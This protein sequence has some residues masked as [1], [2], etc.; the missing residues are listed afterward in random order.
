MPVV[1]LSLLWLLSGCD[2]FCC[3]E[4]EICC[5]CCQSYHCCRVVIVS[6]FDIWNLLFGFCYLRFVFRVVIVVGLWLFFVTS[7]RLSASIW[8]LLW[9]LWLLSGCDCFLLFGF[10]CLDF[11]IWILLF[12][13]DLHN[14]I[15]TNAADTVA[16]VSWKLSVIFLPVCFVFNDC[17][18]LKFGNIPGFFVKLYPY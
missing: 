11:V 3:L 10:C 6:K 14:I 16:G 8:N 12:V 4:F 7:T 2:C 17:I 13:V 9:L 15:T 18:Q 5:L 1:G